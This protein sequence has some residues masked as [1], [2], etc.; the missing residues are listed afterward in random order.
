MNQ[1]VMKHLNIE[2]NL[3]DNILKLFDKNSCFSLNKKVISSYLILFL[4]FKY[5]NNY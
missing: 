2:Q 4:S 1:A 3:K 5:L